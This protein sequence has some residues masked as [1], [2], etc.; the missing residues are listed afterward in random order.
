MD[1]FKSKMVCKE[2]IVKEVNPYN[3]RTCFHS[4]YLIAGLFSS[5]G[6]RDDGGGIKRACHTASST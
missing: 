6:W 5:M 2:D 1:S 3:R 4:L